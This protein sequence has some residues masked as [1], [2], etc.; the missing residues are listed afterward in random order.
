M[1]RHGL[2]APPFHTG[3]VQIG[4]LYQPKPPAPRADCLRLQRA[5]LDDRTT[6]PRNFFQR[7]FGA[8]WSIC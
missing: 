7:L 1:S 5:L 2:K 3:K 6:G 4:L 8:F